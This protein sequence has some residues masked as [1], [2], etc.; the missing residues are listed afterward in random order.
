MEKK[1]SETDI[2]L[3]ESLKFYF[4]EQLR[5][6]NKNSLCPV[7]EET[8]YYSSE[9]LEKCAFSQEFFNFEGGK[10]REKVLGMELLQASA[11]SPE[12]KK[13]AYKD[14]GDT[15]LVMTGYFS[16]SINDKILGSDYYV[17]LGQ[18]AYEK[19]DVAQPKCFDVPSFYK[20]MATCFENLAQMMSVIMQRSEGNQ[21]IPYL[22]SLGGEC[23]K[24]VS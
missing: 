18:M 16:K 2:V 7:P 8:I 4:Y 12:K 11:Y 10:A 23:D 17:R 1:K 14:I 5:D 9:V 20:V 19:L 13:R 3:S 21:E 15:A 24:K 22:L 6:L